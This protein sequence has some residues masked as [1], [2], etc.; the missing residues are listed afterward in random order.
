MSNVR[1]IGIGGAL[2]ASG[3]LIAA[4]LVSAA[5]AAKVGTAYVHDGGAEV[6]PLGSITSQMWV[7][8]GKYHVTATIGLDNNIPGQGPGAF[9]NKVT[10]YLFMDG[11]NT[12]FYQSLPA[13]GYATMALELVVD[14]RTSPLSFIDVECR[15]E[16]AVAPLP[17][18]GV[19][20]VAELIAGFVQIP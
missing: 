17:Y 6:P 15:A 18:A 8:P 20:I 19:R 2:V 14:A 3:M 7:P 11:T 9:V 13:G 5:P 16:G 10:C 12:G 1:R 4:Q